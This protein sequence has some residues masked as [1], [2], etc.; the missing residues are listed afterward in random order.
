MSS[1]TAVT[2]KLPGPYIDAA[3]PTLDST[4]QVDIGSIGNTGTIDI[5]PGPTDDTVAHQ[6]LTFENNAG[7]T[8]TYL[9]CDA[10]SFVSDQVP[11]VGGEKCSVTISN[12]NTK[13]CG[14]TKNISFTF[15]NLEESSTH[16]DTSVYLAAQHEIRD[17]AEVLKD[18]TCEFIEEFPNH[19][20]YSYL[21]SICIQDACDIVPNL[22]TILDEL[23]GLGE[24]NEKEDSTVGIVIGTLTGAV[25]IGATAIIAHRYLKGQ[26]NLKD[27]VNKAWNE[28][29]PSK[30]KK[31]LNDIN[32]FLTQTNFSSRA[33]MKNQGIDPEIL[34]SID[35]LDRDSA[36]LSA[37]AKSNLETARQVLIS[38][39]KKA[40][41][42]TPSEKKGQTA[43]QTASTDGENSSTRGQ[44]A[45]TL[46]S[47]ASPGHSGAISTSGTGDP[48]RTTGNPIISPQLS[49]ELEP[50]GDPESRAS[51]ASRLQAAFRNYQALKA[52]RTQ[53]SSTP[54]SDTVKQ[55]D[56]AVTT[57]QAAFRGFQVR[58][59]TGQPSSSLVELAK[60]LRTEPTSAA[61]KTAFITA[62]KAHI[63]TSKPNPLVAA[64]SNLAAL[65]GPKD[66]S[67][68]SAE[69][70]EQSTKARADLESAAIVHQAML[71]SGDQN[72]IERAEAES[73]ELSNMFSDGK[74]GIED[75]KSVER[76]FESDSLLVT[77]LKQ[78]E[79][80]LLARSV[81]RAKA[82][83]D[84]DKTSKTAQDAL[85]AAQK[86]FQK[87][88]GSKTPSTPAATLDAY[89]EA[90]DPDKK[91]KNARDLL[92]ALEIHEAQRGIEEQ[93]LHTKKTAEF[94]KR[95]GAMNLKELKDLEN[96]MP[97]ATK[98]QPL[99]QR[100]TKIKET[101]MAAAATRIQTQFRG[102][103]ARAQLAQLEKTPP[104][105]LVHRSLTDIFAGLEASPDG[106]T[107]PD[108]RTKALE[109]F[110]AA[111]KANQLMA[112]DTTSGLGQGARLEAQALDEALDK[113]SLP[114]LRKLE[115]YLLDIETPDTSL[116]DFIRS[117]RTHELARAVTAVNN[118]QS[119]V[120][121]LTGDTVTNKQLAEAQSQ[122]KEIFTRPNAPGRVE[123]TPAQAL[124]D[125]REAASGGGNAKDKALR[126]KKEARTVSDALM[127]VEAA[128]LTGTNTTQDQAESRRML[129]EMDDTTVKD[130]LSKMP[131]EGQNLLVAERIKMNAE[132]ELEAR[133]EAAL[134]IQGLVRKVRA[135]QIVTHMRTKRV[136]T[137]S[138]QDPL[139]DGGEARQ[140]NAKF[141]QKAKEIMEAFNQK[142]VNVKKLRDAAKELARKSLQDRLAARNRWKRARQ[143]I[144]VTT[145]FRLASQ[146]KLEAQR[147]ARLE[148]VAGIE[149]KPLKD[150]LKT[151]QKY[152]R[153]LEGFIEAAENFDVDR[154]F[155][156]L[157]DTSKS[158]KMLTEAAKYNLFPSKRSTMADLY[159]E[160]AQ[161]VE[162]LQSSDLK[163]EE[164][165]TLKGRIQNLKEKLDLR[166]RLFGSL[167][168][169]EGLNLTALGLSEAQAQKIKS[170]YHLARGESEEFVQMVKQRQVDSKASYSEIDQKLKA[171]GLPP[172][173]GSDFDDLFNDLSFETNGFQ[174]DLKNPPPKI[175]KSHHIDTPIPEPDPKATQAQELL[176]AQKENSSDIE[177]K[178][179]DFLKSL[180]SEEEPSPRKLSDIA[181]D[182]DEVQRD[183][184]YMEGGG[185]FD[186]DPI[187]PKELE[188]QRN[189]LLSELEARYDVNRAQV[190]LGDATYAPRA[191]YEFQKFQKTLYSNAMIREESNLTRLLAGSTSQDFGNRL[192]ADSRFQIQ[193]RKLLQAADL[194][195]T[196][197]EDGES[198]FY[199]VELDNEK[200]KLNEILAEERA[201]GKTPQSKVDDALT[202]IFKMKQDDSPETRNHILQNFAEA[203]RIFQVG[204]IADDPGL[205]LESNK[206]TT[207][208][209]GLT[210]PE[211]E[212]LFT[213]SQLQSKGYGYILDDLQ[214]RINT[215]HENKAATKIQALMRGFQTRTASQ[216]VRRQLVTHAAQKAV[217]EPNPEEA[218]KLEQALQDAGDTTQVTGTTTDLEQQLDKVEELEI[219]ATDLSLPPSQQTVANDKFKRAVNKVQQRLA[220]ANAL[221]E[222]KDAHPKPRT[223]QEAAA[224]VQSAVAAPKDSKIQERIDRVKG[225]GAVGLPGVAGQIKLKK[226]KLSSSEL[227]QAYLKDP[228]NVELRDQVLEMAAAA[229]A[230]AGGKPKTLKKRLSE[231]QAIEAEIKEAKKT[232]KT[233]TL[234]K[235]E[236]KALTKALKKKQKKQKKQAEKF[237][238]AFAVNRAKRAST[239]LSFQDAAKIEFD[240]AT[241]FAKDNPL[242][243]TKLRIGSYDLFS[244][245]LKAK[246]KKKKKKRKKAGIREGGYVDTSTLGGSTAHASTWVGGGTEAELK[247]RV[248]EVD[249]FI[250]ANEAPLRA[251]NVLQTIDPMSGMSPEKLRAELRI[252]YGES[253]PESIESLKTAN[254][255]TQFLE[256][257]L[258]TFTD[259]D[260][261]RE[262]QSN[263]LEHYKQTFES[264]IKDGYDET[265]K[266]KAATRISTLLSGESK[267]TKIIINKVQNEMQYKTKRVLHSDIEKKLKNLRNLDSSRSSFD[268]SI[269]QRRVSTEDLLRRIGYTLVA[270]EEDTRFEELLN[271][272]ESIILEVNKLSIV[273]DTAQ[274][275]V[276]SDKIEKLVD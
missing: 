23:S 203:Y 230:K 214:I 257:I 185:S 137:T 183:L 18:M 207:R 17:Y 89:N 74:L 2:E 39:D 176:V 206:F 168:N 192:W 251:M 104:E 273:R 191:Q 116:T 59:S 201:N 113:L 96:L 240:E 60:K 153:N 130:L 138:T 111:L 200:L 65:R 131:S 90:K 204:T 154:L 148:T 225:M 248:N 14:K 33:E 255:K 27:L 143:K 235:K 249:R 227:A 165:A 213:T 212:K 16:E 259:T 180:S 99:T 232:K 20:I 160:L 256:A 193:S 231:L 12:C 162:K 226:R 76:V 25:A 197:L 224:T 4:A 126:L 118:A 30:K 83:L 85:Q 72:L 161:T 40:L 174:K 265:G 79:L 190:S 78:H 205:R 80:L 28:D 262:M 158:V 49:S 266:L 34:H 8:I 54:E 196:R 276:I 114:E 198:E 24:E 29:D 233:G 215:A 121:S 41:G 252:I 35:T 13:G 134:K 178:K 246:V 220:L 263:I 146:A 107:D 57:L 132:L 238:Q 236:T 119:I 103:K 172:L 171:M 189:S 5:N 81:V 68:L 199:K 1:Q 55:L 86:Q 45:N 53:K 51:A 15:P 6:E 219:K 48:S 123:I 152:K 97:L 7:E 100:W 269:Q 169:L 222:A 155:T 31:I 164:I 75:L 208:L 156:D 102:Q 159:Q 43:R 44:R 94:D 73:I 63:Q 272:L 177:K 36:F 91:A 38:P 133:G 93:T 188:E 140:T 139:R 229:E 261:E 64:V 19:K 141:K 109:K 210:D 247:A 149:P 175:P 88:L 221:S 135:V 223:I 61:N 3:P 105:D 47:S 92:A 10:T 182:L 21:E 26:E 127:L 71:D 110:V 186:D 271:D 166:A 77:K 242:T 157:D 274:S 69:I 170:G 187:T 167:G 125:Y 142:K 9:I 270:T 11:C 122:L 260:A 37:K 50:D 211:I 194:Y 42:K 147:A 98:T 117:V 150:P 70:Q 209:A 120:E 112:A 237:E 67:E 62:M 241:T 82:A 181:K 234:S 66:V 46:G 239:E 173:L 163:P 258:G 52:L 275:E 250:A 264:E 254:T 32:K 202:A 101:K 108:A 243:Q 216:G 268:P 144:S 195:E 56:E 22:E 267:T 245:S 115:T 95:L 106:D 151:D 184:K 136:E 179:T 145:Q 124:S 217:A 87:A 228:T 128:S 84:S 244:E 218:K 58:N 253:L 129:S